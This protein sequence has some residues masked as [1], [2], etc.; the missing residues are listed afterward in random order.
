M[1]YLKQLI[2]QRAKNTCLLHCK[3]ALNMMDKTSYEQGFKAGFYFGFKRP[4]F[5]MAILLIISLIINIIQF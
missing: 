2:I 1:F 5:I 4:I 3:A